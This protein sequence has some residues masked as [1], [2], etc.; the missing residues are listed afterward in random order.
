L[1]KVALNIKEIH[2]TVND[3]TYRQSLDLILEIHTF[4]IPK[5]IPSYRQ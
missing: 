3:K 1:E 5:I 4:L 2:F